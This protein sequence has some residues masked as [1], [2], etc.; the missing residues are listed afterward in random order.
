MRDLFVIAKFL[1]L[2]GYHVYPFGGET[3]IDGEVF[4]CSH[5]FVSLWASLH[6]NRY[7]PSFPFSKRWHV[8]PSRTSA[9]AC[10]TYGLAQCTTSRVGQ[11]WCCATPSGWRR[12]L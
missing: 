6:E 2:F 7:S 3:Q 5:V 10:L 12:V 9:E 11:V 4:F 8:P 1:Y